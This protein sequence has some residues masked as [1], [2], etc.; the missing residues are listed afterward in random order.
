MKVKIIETRV[1]GRRK[2]DADRLRR[3]FVLNGCTFAATV[4]E[5][6]VVVAVTC[7]FRKNRVEESRQTVGDIAQS[8]KRA[9]VSG[10]YPA[11]ER[12]AF[13]RARTPR[14]A[15][16]DPANMESIDRCFEDFVVRYADVPEPATI[17]MERDDDVAVLRVSSGC[18]Y[19]C[20]FCGIKKAVGEMRS[21]PPSLVRE[22]AER[23]LDLD[24][25]RAIALMGDDVGAYGTDLGTTLPDL[26]GDLRTTIEHRGLPV[27]LKLGNM[28]PWWLTAYEAELQEV[29]E[30]GIVSFLH[31]SLQSGSERIIGL[32][33][34]G[35]CRLRD[36]ERVLTR[37]PREQ[38]ELQVDLIVGFPTETD[39]DFRETLECVERCRPAYANAF[40]YYENEDTPSRRLEPK[41]AA[42]V[43]QERHRAILAR[44]RQL[45]IRTTIEDED[46]DHGAGC[47]GA[48]PD[49]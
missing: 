34:R 19:R 2:M 4:E 36:V 45:G 14:V 15:S 13:E 33:D 20:S 26:L 30:S 32:M 42:S 41:V 43:A 46:E 18:S 28:N 10:C 1:C 49:A 16:V 17:P 22:E 21:K 3:Y 6:D 27:R 7:A 11:M 47:S 24:R 39:E 40:T 8:G 31:A 23:I 5:A 37:L 38:V 9:V 12:R 35:Y 44:F 29:W 25:Y 48:C